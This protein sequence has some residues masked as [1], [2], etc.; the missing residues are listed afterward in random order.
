M[1]SERKVAKGERGLKVK[2][3]KAQRENHQPYATEV[4]D[5]ASDAVRKPVPDPR[6]KQEHA[7]TPDETAA[8]RRKP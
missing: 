6:R 7:T 4:E 1:I 3:V 2:G 8:R 5:Y